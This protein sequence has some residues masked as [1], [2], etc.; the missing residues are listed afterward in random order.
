MPQTHHMMCIYS[1]I[2]IHN[3]KFLSVTT[4]FFVFL[5]EVFFCVDYNNY[6]VLVE[7][8]RKRRAE[9]VCNE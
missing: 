9:N 7:Q 4:S 5:P 1:Q 3:R 8:L 6:A 2:I